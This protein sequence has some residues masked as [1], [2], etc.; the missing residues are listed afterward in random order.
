MRAGIGGVGSAGLPLSPGTRAVLEKLTREQVDAFERAR[1]LAVARGAEWAVASGDAPSTE[2]EVL[3]GHTMEFRERSIARLAEIH[4]EI[5]RLHA[6]EVEVLAGLVEACAHESGAVDEAVALEWGYRDAAAEVAAVTRQAERTALTRLER[7]VQ[8]CEGF[9]ASLG[10]LA[11]GQIS[12]AHLDVIMACGERIED[13]H[14]L[15]V[16]EHLVLDRAIETTPG[17]LRSYARRI[18]EQLLGTSREQRHERAR[19]A[20]F[21]SLTELDDGMS[22]LCAVVPT[23]LGVAIRDRLTRIAT[24]V[25]TANKAD[26]RAG[27]ET[28]NTDTETE[29]RDA[30]SIDQIRADAFCDMLLTS[31]PQNGNAHR[32]TAQVAITVPALTLLGHHND[33]AML[34]GQS[35]I[36]LEDAREWAAN[37]PTL[38]RILTDP[39]TGAPLA[40]NTYR[41]SREL[42]TFLRYRDAHCRFPGCRR[43][44][45][46]CDLDHT[47]DYHHGGTTSHNNLA[48]LCQRHHYLKH[49]TNWQVTQPTPGV[50]EWVSPTGRTFTD[51]PAR[52]GPDLSQQPKFA[53][54]AAWGEPPSRQASASPPGAPVPPPF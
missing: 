53:G 1:A 43:T 34:D 37:A 46:R 38:T 17:R 7:S 21:V 44:A 35:P 52:V 19:A 10:A 29:L 25:I 49:N 27:R 18:V 8:V 39:T 32:I 30:R 42:R 2:R 14:V 23:V 26:A 47:I 6:E 24:E 20:R 5:A 36:S 4:A 9:V 22:E 41:P 50:L 40:V 16:Y 3:V 45:A 12:R 28:A 48:H 11:A 31:D 33:P 51:K 54:A 15:S 13:R